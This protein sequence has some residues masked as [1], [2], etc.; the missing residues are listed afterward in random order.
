MA[1]REMVMHLDDLIRR[2]TMLALTHHRAS[3]RCDKGLPEAAKILFGEN[4][5]QEID[6]YFNAP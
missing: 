1:K 2:R 3:L 5:Q 6:R 4:A